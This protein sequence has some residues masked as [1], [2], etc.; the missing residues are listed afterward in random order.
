MS[1]ALSAEV[2]RDVSPNDEMCV[3]GRESH[4]FQAGQSALDCINCSLQ[5]AQ[6]PAENIHRILDLPCGH[7]RVMR[8]LK[9]AFPDAEITACDLLRDGVDYCA[10]TFDAIPICSDENPEKIKLESYAFDLIWVGSLLTHL[11]AHRWTQFLELFRRTLRPG[12]TLVFS[13]H[14][15]KAYD[16]TRR[17]VTPIHPYWQQTSTL[18]AYERTGFGYCNYQNSNS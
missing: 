9:A 6:L 17:G 16:L 11:D 7:G 8:H 12:G 2:S 10:A 1:I 15:R 3:A 13:A 18:F 5:A 4:Y 14:G